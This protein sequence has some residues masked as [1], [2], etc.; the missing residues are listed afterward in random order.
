MNPLI[1]LGRVKI[2]IVTHYMPPHIGGI[3]LVADSL[4]RAYLAAGLEARWVAA[5][6][7]KT[8]AAREDGRIRV[9]CWNGLERRLGVPWP[10]LG[11]EG[12]RE[13]TKLVRWADVL[14]VHDSLY[15]GSA[16]TTLLARRAHKPVILSQHIGF[17]KYHSALLNGVEHLA[18]QTLGRTLLRSATHLVFCTTAAEQFAGPLRN[19]ASGTTSVIPNGIDTE[20]F[21]P[22]TRAER[23]S[24]RE[25]LKLPK[26]A[27]VVL[28]V[29]RLVE[30]KG[31]DVLADLVK[32]MPSHFFLIVG[33]GPLRTIIPKEATN[34]GWFPE[35]APDGMAKFYQA[36]NVFVLPSH[37]EGLPLSVQEAMATGLPAI[38]SRD[39]PFASMLDLEG[40]CLASARTSEGFCD[41]L[42]RLAVDQ[43]L[44]TSL[45][46]RARELALREWSLGVM[47]ERYLSLIRELS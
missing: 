8:A 25:N 22:P 38:V 16:V 11:L 46:A 29:G 30:K 15:E 10:V 31:I 23:E 24:A 6:E 43:D 19:G 32:R 7:P 40:A 21:R 3:E 13:L 27:R 45:S 1:R 36:S 39:E 34:L 28:F 17:V 44:C 37:G 12:L 18:N 2:G 41:S 9:N 26:S 4:Y 47:T 14:H 35:V 20:R 5:R 33:D 42:E